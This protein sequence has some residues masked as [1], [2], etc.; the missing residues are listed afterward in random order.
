MIA[1]AESVVLARRGT[2]TRDGV[3]RS[4]RTIPL[5]Q[6]YQNRFSPVT[7]SGFPWRDTEAHF[8]ER[9]RLSD[10]QNHGNV[11]GSLESIWNLQGDSIVSRR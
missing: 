10:A 8:A 5:T 1:T 2:K 9:F 11:I 3:V 6:E 4:V 7:S